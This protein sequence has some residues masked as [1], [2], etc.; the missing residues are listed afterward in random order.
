MPREGNIDENERPR[1]EA[2]AGFS[3]ECCTS[4]FGAVHVK[5]GMGGSQTSLQ[6]GFNLELLDV[7][8]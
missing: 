4:S 8:C 2:S 3:L 1:E 5:R 6:F 7:F